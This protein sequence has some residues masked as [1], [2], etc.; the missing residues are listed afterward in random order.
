MCQGLVNGMTSFNLT[1]PH[2]LH[3]PMR[4][5]PMRTFDETPREPRNSEATG[6]DPRAAGAMATPADGTPR[7][8]TVKVATTP[9]PDT[10]GNVE[11]D[12]GTVDGIRAWRKP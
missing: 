1:R 9:L 5:N 4:K 6:A 12:F 8:E 10:V 11:H 3:K 7:G 2:W